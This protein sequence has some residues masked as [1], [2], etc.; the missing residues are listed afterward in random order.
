MI[1]I[2]YLVPLV[3]GILTHTLLVFSHDNDLF[4]LLIYLL[5]VC[6]KSQFFFDNVSL[7]IPYC[8]C[9]LREVGINDPIAQ[10]GS[11]CYGTCW[12]HIV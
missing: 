12:Q 11:Y 7:L 2:K 1:M 9:T 4:T 3:K 5:Q 8:T 10:T 6:A